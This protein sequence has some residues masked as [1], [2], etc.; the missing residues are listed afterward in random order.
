MLALCICVEIGVHL[1]FYTFSYQ[2]Q[3]G[4]YGMVYDNNMYVFY[5][6]YTAEVMVTGQVNIVSTQTSGVTFETHSREAQYFYW[7]ISIVHAMVISVIKCKH[8]LFDKF[9]SMWEIHFSHH[10]MLWTNILTAPSNFSPNSGSL[11]P[12]C[13]MWATSESPFTNLY[14]LRTCL[15]Q[16]IHQFE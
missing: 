11:L 6:L 8:N 15:K 5:I 10:C 12:I 7:C 2:I 16:P 4:T 3:I 13:H 1:W 9:I 14:S